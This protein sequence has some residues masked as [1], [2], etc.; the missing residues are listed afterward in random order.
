MYIEVLGKFI[1][2]GMLTPSEKNEFK[3]SLEKF[4][5]LK[6][7]FAGDYRQSIYAGVLAIL[8]H[9]ELDDEEERLRDF[10]NSIKNN[11]RLTNIERSLDTVVGRE[12]SAIIQQE[13]ELL[14]RLFDKA[15][16]LDNYE[17][18]DRLIVLLQRRKHPKANLL[19][20]IRSVI[21]LDDS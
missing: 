6:E 11:S 2:F 19:R 7:D 5:V 18:L 4:L 14:G 10:V 21:I 17:F 9:F 8:V 1:S 12:Q 16:L 13:D 15:V 3:K 20:G